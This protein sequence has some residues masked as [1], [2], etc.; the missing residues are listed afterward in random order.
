MKKIFVLKKYKPSKETGYSF[1]GSFFMMKFSGFG[2]IYLQSAK[3]IQF[4]PHPDR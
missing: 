4:L 3:A 1:E 2:E